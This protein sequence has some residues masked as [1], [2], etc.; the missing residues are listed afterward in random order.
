MTAIVLVGLV[1]S[2][3]VGLAGIAQAFGEVY[4]SVPPGYREWL[5]VPTGARPVKPTAVI[6]LDVLGAN[7]LAPYEVLADTGAFP[8]YTAAERHEPVPLTGGLDLVPDLS[9]AQLDE[10]GRPEVIVVPAVPDVRCRTPH[11]ATTA[12]P[13]VAM[14]WLWP[15]SDRHLEEDRHDRT[16]HRRTSGRQRAIVTCSAP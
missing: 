7:V 8:L 11:L 1:V 3:G 14:A 6:A 2:V 16:A 5:R 12:T 15:D 10:R 13:I 4:P 9:F